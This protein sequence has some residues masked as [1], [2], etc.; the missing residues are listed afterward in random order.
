MGLI[1]A[2]RR[3]ICLDS[4]SRYSTSVNVSWGHCGHELSSLTIPAVMQDHDT[5]QEISIYQ[6]DDENSCVAPVTLSRASHFDYHHAPRILIQ[7]R[8]KVECI[9]EGIIVLNWPSDNTSRERKG[10]WLFAEPVSCN[11][12]ARTAWRLSDASELPSLQDLARADPSFPEMLS[13]VAMSVSAPQD[14]MQGGKQTKDRLT[15]RPKAEHASLVPG[16]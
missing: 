14:L 1:A 10:P 11:T 15:F 2:L 4:L 6:V 8:K 16:E 5:V 9:S 3:V 13:T 7:L 12:A